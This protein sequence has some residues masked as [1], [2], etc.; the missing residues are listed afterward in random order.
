MSAINQEALNTSL[1]SRLHARMIQ[2]SAYTFDDGSAAVLITLRTNAFSV[3]VPYSLRYDE[4]DDIIIAATPRETFNTPTVNDAV[5]K[6]VKD[7]RMIEV[8]FA[9]WKR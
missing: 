5:A 1:K 8:K 3:Q 6:I 4:V 7:V 2:Y 9:R